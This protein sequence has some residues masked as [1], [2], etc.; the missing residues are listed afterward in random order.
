MVNKRIVIDTNVLIGFE[1]WIPREY[2]K[3]F[4]NELKNKIREKKVII[5]DVVVSEVKYVSQLI[6]WLNELKVEKLVTIV[7]S[8]EKRRALDINNLYPMIDQTTKNSEV[9]TYIIAHAEKFGHTIF[10]RESRRDDNSKL[11]KIPDVCD[12]LGIKVFSKPRRIFKDL[13]ISF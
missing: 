10:S 6:L 1:L 11:Y 9:D 13:E 12:E 2:N 7:S 4:W 5:L 3:P 8:E